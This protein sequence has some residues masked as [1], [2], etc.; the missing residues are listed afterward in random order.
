MDPM[1][2]DAA[3]LGANRGLLKVKCTP[4]SVAAVIKELLEGLPFG[5]PADQLLAA[6]AEVAPAAQAAPEVAGQVA[7]DEIAEEPS[8]VPVI[9]P[10][11]QARQE[12]A[13][14]TAAVA[15]SLRESH[16]ALRRERDERQR[17]LRVEAFYRHIRFIAGAGRARGLSANGANGGGT[18]GA[19]FWDAGPACGA[20]TLAGSHYFHSIGVPAGTTRE[21]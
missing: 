15:R 2:Q 12:L 9:A 3:R 11:E 8:P 20:F 19:G 5:T 13:T 6:P 4:A 14:H 1:A 17:K 21:S 10:R 7:A 18:G 16:E